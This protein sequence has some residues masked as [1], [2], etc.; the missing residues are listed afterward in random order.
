M[1][2]GK[3][4]Y[5]WIILIVTFLSVI[6]AAVTNT[7]SGV[8]MIPFEKEFGW[9]RASISGAFA[10]CITLVG[11]SGPFI[12]GLYQKF[13][14]R[15]VLLVGMGTLLTA[16]LL[17]TIMSQIWHL[18]IIWGIIIGLSAGAFLTVLNAYVAT[19]W[20]EKKR[21]LALGLLTSSSAAGQ[22]VFLPLMAYIVENYSWRNAVL[23]IFSFGVFIYVLLWIFMKNDPADVGVLPLGA[24]KSNQKQANNVNPV[25]AAFDGFKLGAKSKVFWLLAGSFFVCGFSTSGL[26]GTHFI[27]LCIDY[28]YKEVTAASILAFMGIFNIIG[29]TLSGYISDRFD[30][31]WLLFWYYGL[32]GLSLLILPFALST[33]SIIYLS[34]FAIFYGMDWIATVPPT[35]KLATDHFGKEKV[36]VIYGWI[37]TAHQLGAGAAAYGGGLIYSWLNAYQSIFIAAG[38]FCLVA[39]LFVL[40]IK[41]R[42]VLNQNLSA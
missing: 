3:I 1:K 33:N 32:R 31:R 18:F 11:F 24:E 5:A 23:T 6:I 15:K 21:G 17:T 4:H 30:N 13:S 7:M 19:T 36:G 40:N 37:Y 35:I 28:G 29:T 20:F 42:A 16:I 2:S 22:L 12:A 26:I 25:K 14:V 8:M 38:I 9:S 34:A 27:S 39:T 10:I 41:K